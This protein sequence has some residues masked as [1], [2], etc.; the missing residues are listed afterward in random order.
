MPECFL[1]RKEDSPG[2]SSSFSSKN[3]AEE[4]RGR[5]TTVAKKTVTSRPEKKK[6]APTFDFVDLMKKVLLEL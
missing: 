2:P 6:P 3:K 4:R 5:T 1:L